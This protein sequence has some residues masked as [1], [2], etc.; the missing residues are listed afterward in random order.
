MCVCVSGYVRV[1]HPG[2]SGLPC[3]HGFLQARFPVGLP[4][5]RSLHH[6]LCE[7]AAAEHR[8]ISLWSSPC[9]CGFLLHNRAAAGDAEPPDVSGGNV[10]LQHC[11]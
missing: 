8:G 11:W 1:T 10:L 6:T 5:S 2:I 4:L 9:L 7:V 3:Q